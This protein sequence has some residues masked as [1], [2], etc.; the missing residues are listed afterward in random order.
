MEEYKNQENGTSPNKSVRGY[1]IVV[2][3]LAVLLAGVAVLYFMQTNKIKKEAEV[4]KTILVGEINELRTDLDNLQTTHTAINDSLDGE[5]LRV[6]SLYQAL[7]KE[8]NVSRATIRKYENELKTL[9]DVMRRYVVQIDSLNALNRALA[10]ENV[11]YRRQASNERLRAEV[12][13][14]RATELDQRVKAGSVIR[15]R[16]I[17]LVPLNNNDKPVTRASRAVRLQINFILAGNDIANAGQR[18]VYA[19]ITGP[20]GYV[21]AGDASSLFE[22]QGDRITYSAARD[23][24]YQ[25]TD[26][27][28]G[29]YYNGEI[30]SGT[31][32]VEIYMDGHKIGQTETI[33]K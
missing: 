8:R 30:V 15:A 22:F 9:K 26:L 23:V 25:N 4:E 31:Y 18:T 14:E 28:V 19:R 27:S 5:R 2:I 24:D 32:L 3:L 6:D 12:A 29:L 11:T 21:M 16:D 10:E 20:D 33:L 13:E 1:Q 17:E 7:Q